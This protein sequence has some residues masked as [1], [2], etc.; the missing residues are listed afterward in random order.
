LKFDFGKTVVTVGDIVILGQS[1]I[2]NG[3]NIDLLVANKFLK[4]VRKPRAKKENK[5]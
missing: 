5:E 1:D 2:D 3:Y 4:E